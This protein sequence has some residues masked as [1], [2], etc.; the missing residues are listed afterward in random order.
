MDDPTTSDENADGVEHA[1]PTASPESVG[2]TE[3]QAAVLA[4]ETSW[5]KYAG[6]KETAVRDQFGW[7]MTRYYQVLN[8]LIDTP[9][10][11]AVDPVTVNRLRRLREER[12]R[13][14]SDRDPS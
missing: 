13:A 4:L 1:E 10:A 9:A 7:S 5:W 6:A 14:R 11:L 3:V 8:A 2:L 12:Q